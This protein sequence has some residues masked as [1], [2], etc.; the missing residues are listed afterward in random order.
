MSSCFKAPRMMVFTLRC[1]NPLPGKEIRICLYK[2][3]KF[4]YEG[5]E[6]NKKCPQC[7]GKLDV[8]SRPLDPSSDDDD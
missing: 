2:G 7:G 4:G 6:L 5:E 8:S 3:E 1:C